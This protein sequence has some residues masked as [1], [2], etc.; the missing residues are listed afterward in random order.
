MNEKPELLPSYLKKIVNREHLRPKC[1]ELG[2]VFLA[3]R[4]KDHHLNFV[5]LLLSWVFYNLMT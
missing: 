1:Q 3:R 4:E 5:F 2:E